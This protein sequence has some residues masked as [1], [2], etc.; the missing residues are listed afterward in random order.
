MPSVF[1]ALLLCW[2]SLAAHAAPT[3]DKESY[4]RRRWTL[5][6]GAPQQVTTLAQTDDGM[7]WFASPNGIYSFDGIRFRR[8]TSIYGQRIPSVNISAMKVMPGGL[9]L[10]YQFG[11]L[12]VFTRSGAT[13]YVAGKDY[14]AGSTLS[15]AI[16]RQGVLH[17][18]TNSGLVRLRKGRWDRSARTSL[19]RAWPRIS[20]STATALYGPTS[21]TATTPCRSVQTI[22][23]MSS[24]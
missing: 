15:L 17:A 8:A 23:A 13:H 5:A 20:N 10:A 6:D 22:F 18:A 16:D 9:A 21:T 7:L 4:E 24:I 1:L 14:P 3:A 12:S 2:L 19:C 11:G